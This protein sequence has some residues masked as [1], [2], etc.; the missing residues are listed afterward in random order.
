MNT[1]AENSIQILSN[2]KA[3]GWSSD[4][5]FT[6]NAARN[7]LRF[8]RSLPGYRETELKS[9]SSA[10]QKYGVKAIYVKDESTRFGLK[11]FKGL[12]G[13]Y[14][15]FRCLCEKLGMDPTTAVY[16]DF[17][18]DV[19]REQCGSITFVTA[20]DGNHGKGVAWAARLFGC[21]SHVF[22]PRGSVEARRQAIEA[23]GADTAVITDLNYDGTVAYAGRLAEEK[24]WI[25]VQDTAWEGY[26]DIPRWIIEGYL[27]MAS[28]A[29]EQMNGEIPTHVFL[30]AG[31]GAMAGG[32]AGY[33][34]NRYGAARPAVT[35]AEPVA[36][37]CVYLSAEAGDGR[38]HSVEG[39][40]VTI[41]AGLNCGTPCS[42][43]WPVLRDGASFCCACNDCITE[44][45]MRAYAYPE[46]DDPVIVSGES[47]AVTYGLLLSILQREDLRNAWAI[48]E[49]SVVLL[50][51]TEGDTDPEGYRRIVEQSPC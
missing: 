33:L 29:C 49:N 9:L 12:G 14:A 15:V 13:S 35:I 3:V 8:H 50:I 41:M 11:A 45:G 10:A 37:A 19:I 1:S 48:D 21:R 40:P 36:A 22:M 39:D 31:V 28:E 17:Q 2:G 4:T 18:K 23:A 34:I 27:T 51:S 5:L 44:Q 32:V 7:A 46:G 24:G 6:Q 16:G 47:G 43:T 30:Q 25:L 20:T 26:E 42:I 38:I